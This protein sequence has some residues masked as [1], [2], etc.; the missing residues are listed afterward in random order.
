[1]AN[2]YIKMITRSSD[3]LLAKT[4]IVNEIAKIKLL[5]NLWFGVNFKQYNMYQINT[6][7]INGV[8]KIRP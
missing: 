5:D 3:F 8:R 1:M 4:L 6:H 7:K 2:F